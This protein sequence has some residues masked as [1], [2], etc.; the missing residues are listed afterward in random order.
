MGKDYYAVLGVPR[1][2]DDATI[3]KAYKK[4]ALKHHPD[5]NI[6][7]Q[8]EAEK[9]FKEIGEAFQVLTDP[10]KRQIYDQYGEEGLKGGIPGSAGGAG[11]V[12]FDFRDAEDIFAQFFGGG[13]GRGFSFGGGNGGRG[14]RGGFQTFNMG[15]GGGGFP[16]M[17]GFDFGG[18]GGDGG[19]GGMG[20]RSRGGPVKDP[21]IQRTLPLTLDEL[22]TGT[23]KK[24]KITR[25]LYDASGRSTQ[26]QKIVEIEVKPGWKPGTKV[27]F[28]EMGD[29][30]PGHIPA[31]LV[32]VVEEKP[33]ALFKREG[34][35][36]IVNAIVTLKEALCGTSVMV[37]TLSG[38]NLKIN[39]KDVISPNYEKRVSGEGMPISK[40]PSQKGDLIIRFQVQWPS[41]LN[42]K[43]KTA[44]ANVL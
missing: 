15:G 9:K 20:G 43:Q 42:E 16:G 40:N 21:P 8:E 22:Y 18:M 11:G 5:R 32:F 23:T 24:M 1:D 13:G 3:K 2:A 25:T 41:H 34:N 44:L 6:D 28:A 12:H 38:R 35:N 37:K 19:F 36:L 27:T 7:K 39:V 26:A 10:E 31:D 29:E 30:Q 33:H 4:L 17:G 14:S